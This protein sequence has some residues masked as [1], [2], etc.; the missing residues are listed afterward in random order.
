MV[1]SVLGRWSRATKLCEP[2]QDRKVATVTGLFGCSGQLAPDF[3]NPPFAIR[4]F[5]L[6][7]SRLASTTDRLMLRE[8]QALAKSAKAKSLCRMN[9]HSS[10]FYI[11]AGG[12]DCLL[13]IAPRS[14]RSE[15]MFRPAFFPIRTL[16]RWWIPPTSGS[17]SAPASA[18]GTWRTKEWPPAIS[19]SSGQESA[20]IASLRFAGSRPDRRRHRHARHDVS[21]HRLPG[22]AQAGHRPDLGLR[23][24]RRML[25]ISVCAERRRQLHRVGPLQKGAG[26]RL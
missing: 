20:A 1:L 19:P 25:G 16:K 2:R 12:L 13:L 9:L 10:C 14:R 6:R 17:W 4:C 23:R 18:N 8:H 11:C 15:P 22:T 5:P 3:L 7:T 21:L 26:H 24:L